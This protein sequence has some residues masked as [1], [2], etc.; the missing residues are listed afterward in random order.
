MLARLMDTYCHPRLSMI[1][2]SGAGPALFVYSVQEPLWHRASN[3]FVQAG[4]RSQ[5]E[6]D[7]FAISMTVSEW[8]ITC[9][10]HYTMVAVCMSLAVHRFNLPLTFR[11]CFYPILGAYTWGWIG[12]FIDGI[13]I[14]VTVAGS[15]TYLGTSVIQIVSGFMRM[16]W[17]N[18]D[19]TQAEMTS[20][21]NMTIWVVIIAS[22]VAVISGL[23]SGIRL[24]SDA[25]MYLAGILLL[26]VFL[27]DDTKFLVR[28][29]PSSC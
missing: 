26:V 10:T 28:I 9:W 20:V 5:D 12:D 22:T 3:F 14:V 29:W 21:Q 17:L 13:A 23:R 4:Y 2:A 27:M 6:V 1:F 18:D 11:S 24:M 7:M 15:C 25:S 16:G 19:I 8:G